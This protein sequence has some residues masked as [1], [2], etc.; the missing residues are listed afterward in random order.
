MEFRTSFF[1]LQSRRAIERL[2]TKPDGILRNHMRMA[3]G[4]LRD[5]CVYSILPH[6]WPA[7]KSNLEFKLRQRS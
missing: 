3:D 4:T 5:T 7:V 2:G 6:E 1:N